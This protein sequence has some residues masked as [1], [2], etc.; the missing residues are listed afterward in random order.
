MEVTVFIHSQ[1]VIA[2]VRAALECSVYVAPLDPGLSYD[3]IL[4]VGK[5]AG[6]QEGELND[7]IHQAGLRSFGNRRFKPEVQ[8]LHWDIFGFDEQPEYRN[9]RAFDVIYEEFNRLI[10][11][12]GGAQA[13]LER[14]VLVERAL[15]KGIKSIDIEAAITISLLTEQLAEKGGLL[16]RPHGRVYEPLPSQQ[17]EQHRSGPMRKPK[18]EQAYQLVKAVVDRRSD[19][20]PKHAE[21]LD[22]FGEALTHLGYSHFRLWWKQTLAE[23]DRSDAASFPTSICVLAA[24]LVEGALTFVVKHA[25]GRGLAVMGS[26]T[27][28]EDPRRWKIDDLV[29]SAAKGGESAILNAAI[30]ARADRLIGLRQRIHAGRMLSEYPGGTPDLRPEEAREARESAEIVVRAVLDWLERYPVDAP[31]AA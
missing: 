15:S 29:E 3:E 17:A 31:P 4:A 8:Y 28:Q 26:K 9:F 6:Y 7:A 21:P 16:M 10:K 1:D 18:R 13:R 25:Q 14:R 30:R 5:G 20:H 12:L 19:E 22:A 24:A 27:F 2:F 23:L 11:S